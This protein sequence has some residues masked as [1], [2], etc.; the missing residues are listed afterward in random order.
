ML[1]KRLRSFSFRMLLWMCIFDLMLACATIAGPLGTIEEEA[2]I[3]NEQGQNVIRQNIKIG[4]DYSLPL[5][6]KMQAAAIQFSILASLLWTLCFAIHLFRI[7]AVNVNPHQTHSYTS[8]FLY[9][10]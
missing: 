10:F 9:L 7:S 8:L 1:N 5:T 3:P 4:D 2:G 6:C